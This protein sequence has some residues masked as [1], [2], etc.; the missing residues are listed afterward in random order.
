MITRLAALGLMGLVSA[1]VTAKAPGVSGPGVSEAPALSAGGALAAS[2]N[3]ADVVPATGGE[4]RSIEPS[5]TAPFRPAVGRLADEPAV[6]ASLASLPKLPLPTRPRPAIVSAGRHLECVPYARK[7]SG[8]QIRGNAWTWWAKATG[9]YDRGAAPEPG[10]V[11]VWSKTKRLRQG[12]L[13]YVVA[14]LNEREVLVHQSNWLNRG[15]IHRYTPVRDVSRNNDWSEVQVWYTP[16]QRYGSGRYPI[17]GFV[18]PND[19]DDV[20]VLQAAN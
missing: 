19:P 15:R 8:I 17:Y 1:C 3:A 12:H 13:A 14:V 5:Y 7:L 4:R 6:Q 20:Q 9:R 11:M 18:Y 2:P 10:A 16:G